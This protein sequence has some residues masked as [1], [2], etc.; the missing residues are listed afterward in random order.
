MDF[1]STGK[2]ILS[3]IENSLNGI[4]ESEVQGFIT[5]LMGKKRIFVIGVGRVMLMMKA[6]AKRLKHL[7]FDTYVV[8]ETTIP[9]IS[10]GDLLIAASG[11]GE[12][13]TTLCIMRLA[14]KH[15]ASIA[16]ISAVPKSTAKDISD[17][18]LIIPSS[19]KL[20]KP[21][22][23]ISKQ[24]MTNLFEQCLLIVCDTVSIIIQQKLNISEDQLWQAHANLE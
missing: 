24:P 17:I 3:E 5:F 20:H 12:T 11:S 4:Q 22:E 14:K 8:G 15:G 16:L 18:S 19:T 9:G 7:G 6:F 10:E 1:N 13:A 23:V 2:F 21:D